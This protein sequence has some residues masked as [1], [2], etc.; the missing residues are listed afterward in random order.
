MTHIGYLACGIHDLETQ[1]VINSFL[2]QFTI[3]FSKWLF[4]NRNNDIISQRDKY[5][6]ANCMI[7]AGHSCNEFETENHT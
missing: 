7:I 1:L 3:M 4:L 6:Y 5:F 2:S